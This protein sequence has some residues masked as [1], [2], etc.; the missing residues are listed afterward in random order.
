[1]PFHRFELPFING[2]PQ[3]MSDWDYADMRRVAGW[4]AGHSSA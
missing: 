4:F 3:E 1:M 2:D